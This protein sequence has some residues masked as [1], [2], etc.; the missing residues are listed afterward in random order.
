MSQTLEELYEEKQQLYSDKQE[1]YRQ[2][3]ALIR[4]I[5]GYKSKISNLYDFI[6]TADRG[7]YSM[8]QAIKGWK[9]DIS[10]LKALRDE[11]IAGLD[12]IQFRI[13]AIEGQI[14]L[15]KEKIEEAKEE[16][17]EER[18]AE[19]EQRRSDRSSGGGYYGGGNRDYGGGGST[20]RSDDTG[21]KLPWRKRRRGE[22]E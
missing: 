11:A 20:S 6:N 10:N 4:D 5:R 3:E 7:N 12:L 1:E 21:S 9:Q 13:T 19:R 14:R 2:K 8:R 15:C 22:W 17:R 16:R 18:E